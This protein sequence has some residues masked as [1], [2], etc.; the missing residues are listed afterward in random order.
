[1]RAVLAGVALACIAGAVLAVLRGDW[2]QAAG[3]AFGF[4][5]ACGWYIAVSVSMA[6]KRGDEGMGRDEGDE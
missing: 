1:M 6:A 4:W 5:V 3:W 2:G